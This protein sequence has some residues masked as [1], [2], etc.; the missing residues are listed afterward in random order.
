MDY[1]QALQRVESLMDAEEGSIE[2]DELEVLSIL[3]DDYENKTFQVEL[4]TALDA[5]K[6]RM[7]Q[8]GWTQKDLAAYLNSRSR[9]SEILSGKRS[10]PKS[11]IRKLHADLNIPAELLIK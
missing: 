6:F 2:A 11:L 9:A 3:V 7:D 8:L 10:I 4:P 5:L 1:E